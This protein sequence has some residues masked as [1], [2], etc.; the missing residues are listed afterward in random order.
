MKTTNLCAIIEAEQSE[1]RCK[2]ID[3]FRCFES[4]VPMKTNYHTHSQ[5]CRHAQGTE[6]DYVRCALDAGVSI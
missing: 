4:E 5:R 1:T 3:L 2:N 6:E